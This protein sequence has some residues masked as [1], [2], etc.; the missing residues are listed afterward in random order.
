MNFVM[1]DGVEEYPDDI[2][3]IL[4]RIPVEWGR[5]ISCDKGWYKLLVDT[6]RKM[7]MMWPNYEIHQ[8]KEK[9]GSLRFYW[10]ISSEDKDWEALDE[11]ISK[12]IYEIMG[13]IANSA[14]S[15][16][17]RICE[18]CGKFGTTTVLNYWYRTLCPACSV[19]QGYTEEQEDIQMFF[20][21]VSCTCG[22]YYGPAKKKLVKDML[23]FHKEIHK[24]EGLAN[25]T[26]DSDSN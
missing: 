22:W 6:N 1:P 23:S 3:D 4:N 7:N 11:N 9:F 26:K 18:D 13:D 19:E 12:T 2:L 20:H 16:S 5:W 17:S 24:L 14:E 8:V 21:T 15:R 10:G 25:E